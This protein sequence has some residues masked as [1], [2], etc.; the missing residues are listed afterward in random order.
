MKKVPPGCLGEKIGVYYVI[1]PN[2]VG[3]DYNYNKPLLNDF[4]GKL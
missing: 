4:L 2:F 1:L 3:I